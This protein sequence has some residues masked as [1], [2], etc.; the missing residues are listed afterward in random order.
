ME[1]LAHDQSAGIDFSGNAQLAKILN[2]NFSAS[3]YYNEIDAS[4]IGYSKSKAA[5]SWNAKMNISVNVTK[6]TMVQVN[7]QYRSSVL[8]P[9]G[10]RYPSGGVNLG[11]RQDFWKKRVSV[12]ITASDIFNTNAMK[13]TVD[14]PVLVQ[15]SVRKRDA[16]IIYAGVVLNFSTTNKKAKEVKFEFDNGGER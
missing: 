2:L 15:E 12:L 13:N 9:Q 10:L 5:L 8:T 16:P 1:N 3:G 7:G 4:N 14:T 11:F 6:T